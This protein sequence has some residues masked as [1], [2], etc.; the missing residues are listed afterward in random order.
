MAVGKMDILI[1]LQQATESKSATTGQMVTTWSDWNTAFAELVTVKASEGEKALQLTS[2]DDRIFRIRYISGV[3]SKMRIYEPEM[4][5][6]Y[7][8]TGIMPE[9]RKNYLVL[10][11]RSLNINSPA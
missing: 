1:T 7:S 6:Y 4:G 2:M 8:I 10:H 3:T 5:R 11:A 9:G